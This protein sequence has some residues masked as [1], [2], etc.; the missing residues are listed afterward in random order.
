MHAQMKQFDIDLLRHMADNKEF[1]VEECGSL[2]AYD[3]W[4]KP[5]LGATLPPSPLSAS[6]LLYQGFLA[7]LGCF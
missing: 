4:Q 3:A 6:P 2:R 1:Y 5:D 7:W